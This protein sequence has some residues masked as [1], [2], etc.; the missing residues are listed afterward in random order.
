MRDCIY[1]RQKWQGSED[2]VQGKAT[3]IN[4]VVVSVL[5]AVFFFV[6]LFSFTP[7]VES[8]F[9]CSCC[10]VLF[11]S[12]V[13][14]SQPSTPTSTRNRHSYTK[15]TSPSIVHIIASL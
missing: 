7:V 10:S 4:E 6:C 9:R 2:E 8:S 3:V 13:S 12:F 1:I 15:S 11:S 14:T 5:D